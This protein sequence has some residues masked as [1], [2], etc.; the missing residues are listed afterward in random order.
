M[1]LFTVDDLLVR[2]VGQWPDRPFLIA[3][4]AI[5]TFGQLGE[6]VERFAG[7]LYREGVRAGDRVGVHV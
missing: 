4:D 3:G 7:W 2:A 5:V 6:M 1:S